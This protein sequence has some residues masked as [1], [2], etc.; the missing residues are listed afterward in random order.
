MSDHDVSQIEST[1][2]GLDPCTLWRVYLSYSPDATPVEVFT[3]S[4]FQ[5]L[6]SHLKSLSWLL[7]APNPLKIVFCSENHSIECILNNNTTPSAVS[8]KPVRRA[9]ISRLRRTEEALARRPVVDAMR[10]ACVRTSVPTNIV[11]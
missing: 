5:M 2:D 3:R 9:F 7:A 10:G 11:V 1:L 4:G 8:H 6:P